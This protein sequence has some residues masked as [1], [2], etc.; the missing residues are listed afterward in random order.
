MTFEERIDLLLKLD[1][2]CLAGVAL[3][4][5]TF[6]YKGDETLIDEHILRQTEA[7]RILLS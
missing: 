1:Q 6:I 3:G 7:A 2:V 4:M 5:I